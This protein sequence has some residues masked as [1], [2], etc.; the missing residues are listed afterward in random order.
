[1]LADL[2]GPKLS[3]FELTYSQ[4]IRQLKLKI[5]RPYLGKKNS[6]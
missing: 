2:A 3:H 1:M 4:E 5:I 6:R